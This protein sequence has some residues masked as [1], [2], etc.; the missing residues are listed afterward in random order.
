VV[1]RNCTN[2]KTYTFTNVA[3]DDQ[4]IGELVITRD[5]VVWDGPYRFYV[6]GFS[7]LNRRYNCYAMDV[8]KNFVDLTKEGK[9]L[10]A[11][12]V[13][14]VDDNYINALDISV[15]INNIYTSHYGGDLNQD[16]EVNSLDFSNQL[17]NFY[18]FG[19]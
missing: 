4:G 13:S 18:T 19:D 10:L 8:A 11:G 1:L 9:D 17:F 5:T 16:T 7:H 3:V 12:E 14:I 2:S 15:L 6:K